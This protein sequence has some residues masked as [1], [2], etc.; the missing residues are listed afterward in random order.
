MAEENYLGMLFH[1]VQHFVGKTWKNF[2]LTLSAQSC[3]GSQ[4]FLLQKPGHC[5]FISLE[6]NNEAK[7][8]SQNPLFI[9]GTK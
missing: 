7:L 6:F 8:L 2:M 9:L 1:H 5:L 3:T 4:Q